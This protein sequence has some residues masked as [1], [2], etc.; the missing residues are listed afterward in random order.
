MPTITTDTIQYSCGHTTEYL[1]QNPH[2]VLMMRRIARHKDCD[3]CIIFKSSRGRMNLV[4]ALVGSLNR[5]RGG[6]DRW[7]WYFPPTTT[8]TVQRAAEACTLCG[9][10][11]GECVCLNR[12]VQ[13]CQG[14]GR[15]TRSC[16]C[17]ELGLILGAQRIREAVRQMEMLMPDVPNSTWEDLHELTDA[18]EDITGA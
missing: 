11:V 9:H 7:T 16:R 1:G 17:E 18:A 3:A 13:F 8:Y 2:W 12:L 15:N 14:C 4:D 5:R 10:P 6:L